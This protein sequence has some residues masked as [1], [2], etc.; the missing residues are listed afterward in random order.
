MR[1]HVSPNR[2]T[3]VMLAS[4]IGVLIVIAIAF[5]YPMRIAESAPAGL[6]ATLRCDD[7]FSG[8]VTFQMTLDHRPVTDPITLNCDEKSAPLP[9]FNDLTI[10]S[11]NGCCPAVG[12]PPDRTATTNLPFKNRPPTPVVPGPVVNKY[13]CDDGG[14]AA[15]PLPLTFLTRGQFVIGAF[16]PGER[17]NLVLSVFDRSTRSPV[18]GATV[19]LVDVKTSR[20]IGVFTT[21]KDGLANIALDT[22]E[23]YYIKISNQG[24]SQA[25]TDN[26]TVF[27]DHTWRVGLLPAAPA[28]NNPTVVNRSTFY[29][30]V[31]I[32]VFFVIA[33]VLLAVRRKRR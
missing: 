8:S 2:T 15:D 16:A 13:V 25:S 28:A 11:Y 20:S 5:L 26:F 23:K 1:S 4:L 29:A 19:E 21:N 14:C 6:V 24:Y 12:G 3:G 17:N 31:A 7:G 10:I 9:A 32:A 22:G 18:G 33:T 30:V 27:E